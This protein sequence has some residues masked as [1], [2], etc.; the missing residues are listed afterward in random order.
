MKRNRKGIAM[1]T[2]ISTA[3]VLCMALIWPLA[4]GDELYYLVDEHDIMVLYS[5]V[6]DF[7]NVPIPPNWVRELIRDADFGHSAGPSSLY[8]RITNVSQRD[9]TLTGTN[10]T[11]D[12]IELSGGDFS[13]LTVPPSPQYLPPGATMDFSIEFTPSG[14][15]SEGSLLIPYR[16]SGKSMRYIVVRIIGEGP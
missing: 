5:N 15:W 14:G 2:L 13:P 8:F 7:D 9:V 12:I 11:P 10:E 1:K 16:P 4:C 3:L 6:N